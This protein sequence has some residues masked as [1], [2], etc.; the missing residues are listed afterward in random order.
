M[1]LIVGKCILKSRALL[2]LHLNS[3]IFNGKR[4]KLGLQEPE[5]LHFANILKTLPRV[6]I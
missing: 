5:K 6:K 1:D 4:L 2:Q 3:Q